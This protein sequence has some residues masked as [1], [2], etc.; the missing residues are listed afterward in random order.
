ML[1]LGVCC[2]DLFLEA[3]GAHGNVVEISGPSKIGASTL[4][5]QVADSFIRRQKKVLYVDTMLHI[6]RPTRRGSGEELEGI[7]RRLIF[8]SL[9][10]AASRGD[11]HLTFRRYPTFGHF[12]DAKR[13]WCACDLIVVDT[14]T[15]ISH[16]VPRTLREEELLATPRILR[17]NHEKDFFEWAKNVSFATGTTWLVLKVA[18]WGKDWNGGLRAGG[19]ATCD[20][21]PDARIWL[22]GSAVESCKTHFAER[23][24]ESSVGHYVDLHNSREREVGAVVTTFLEYGVGFRT[25]STYLSSTWNTTS[26]P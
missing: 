4:A 20:G 24:Q 22:A 13:E 8:P 12:A 14:A 25:G 15:F 9:K 11:G 7:S 18:K 2:L 1:E 16:G 17:A 6:T 26:T 3:T 10:A 23:N 5:L 21:Y 19:G